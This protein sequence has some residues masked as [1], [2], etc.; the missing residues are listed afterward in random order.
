VRVHDIA[1]QPTY[2]SSERNQY[3]HSVQPA[4][5]QNIDTHANRTKS[6]RELTLV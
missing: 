1:L 2:D 6:S 3:L 4:F 5:I